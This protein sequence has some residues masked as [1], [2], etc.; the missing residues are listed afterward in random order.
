[1]MSIIVRRWLG[2]MMH[3]ML[4]YVYDAWGSRVSTLLISMAVVTVVDLAPLFQ[5]KII[6]IED[7]E[8]MLYA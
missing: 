7:P 3:D 8:K 6:K 1:M 5:R 2:V 4:A